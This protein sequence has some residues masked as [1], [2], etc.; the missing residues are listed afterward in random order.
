MPD[1]TE[2]APSAE[3]VP[4][5][6]PLP[7]RRG[8]AWLAW[9]VILLVVGF[10]VVWPHLRRARERVG[11]PDTAERVLAE[12][13]VRQVVG[14]ADLFDNRP[15]LYAEAKKSMD[16][17]PVADRLR[18]LVV[19][20]E[21]QGPGEALT[22]LGQLEQ[23]LQQQ[24]IEPTEEQRTVLEALGRLYRDRTVN[25]ALIAASAVSGLA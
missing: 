5:T 19:A 21:L 3:P 11:G 23:R 6:P 16:T 2:A 10:E 18:F 7:P 20:G 4:P 13:Q 15:L 9:L 1:P 17:G 22:Q 14:W 8:V 25:E 12:V 24:R